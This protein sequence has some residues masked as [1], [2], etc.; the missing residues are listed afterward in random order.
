[1]ED[2]QFKQGVSR[3]FE[4]G[5]RFKIAIQGLIYYV[6]LIR[7]EN[8]SAIVEVASTAKQ[9]ATMV[10]GESKRFDVTGNGVYDL[11][12]ILISVN[13]THAGI[14]VRESSGDVEIPV[15]AVAD[16][17]QQSPQI[18]PESSEGQEAGR[19]EPITGDAIDEIVSPNKLSPW[20]WVV[21]GI[22]VLMFLVVVSVVIKKNYSRK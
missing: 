12:V 10:A 4:A 22:V 15:V 7:L 1:L 6:S 5:D 16:E 9:R 13:E 2:Y 14:F 3:T 17:T 19:K 11:S 21:I 8:N 18:V 20:L